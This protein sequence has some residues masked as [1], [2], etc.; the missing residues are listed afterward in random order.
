MQYAAELGVAQHIIWQDE[1]VSSEEVDRRL[2]GSDVYMTPY[3]EIT[4]T[5]GALLEAMAHG[6]AILSTAYRHATE[7]LSLDKGV[8]VPFEDDVAI[9]AGFVK[10][11][12]SRE[13]REG[14]GIRAKAFVKN[15]TWERVALQYHALLA[16]LEINAAETWGKGLQLQT[17][18]AAYVE[19]LLLPVIPDPFFLDP[20]F[21]A[22][23]Y[24]PR[25]RC[26]LLLASF[27]SRFGAEALIQVLFY[28]A[29]WS[30]LSHPVLRSISVSDLQRA[31]AEDVGGNHP[32]V[33]LFRNCEAKY[34]TANFPCSYAQLFDSPT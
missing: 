29:L 28:R 8:L 24:P 27:V 32:G 9:T 7:V 11:L 23:L 2:Y 34:S 16:K 15:W 33:E 14:Y 18:G 17:P 6:C 19:E 21:D 13:V 31:W 22:H 10:L 3:D 20:A 5:S 12:K 1:Y 4:P 25:D 30:L 26:A